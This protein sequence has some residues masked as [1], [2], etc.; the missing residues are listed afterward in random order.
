MKSNTFAFLGVGT[1]LLLICY[2]VIGPLLVIWA[3]N[4]LFVN[5]SIEYSFTTWLSVVILASAIRS[6]VSVTKD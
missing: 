6:K 1:I 4:T 5:L 3:L 2:I